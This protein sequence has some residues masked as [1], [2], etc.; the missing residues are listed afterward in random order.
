MHRHV[1][2]ERLK[3]SKDFKGREGEFNGGVKI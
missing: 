3:I 1:N 2:S